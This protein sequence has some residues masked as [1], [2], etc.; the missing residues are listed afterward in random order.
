MQNY[1]ILFLGTA[2]FAVPILEGLMESSVNIQSVFTAPPKVANRGLKKTL[3]PVGKFAEEYQLPLEYP[4]LK[5]PKII[6]KIKELNPD[7]IFVIAYGYILPKEIIEIPK[8]GCFNFHGSIL[9]K[10]RGAAPIQ[11]AIIAGEKTT[12][13][14]VIKVDQGL[15]TGDIV[16]DASIEITDEDTYQDLEKKLSQLS[17]NILPMFFEKLATNTKMISQD[18]TQATYAEKI[19]KTEAKIDWQDDA[20]LINQKIRAFNPNPGAWFELEGKRI[21]IM[22]SKVIDKNGKPGEILTDEFII[23]CGSHAIQPTTLKKEGKG[24]VT[25]AEFLKG[26]Q[27][28]PGTQL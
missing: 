17:K 27:V 24:L 4:D 16:L 23:A 6:N 20:Q 28:I 21:K 3:S 26:N 13:V 19:N 12:G 14:T 2:K 22:G 8:F 1:N 10:Y 15:D 11:R 25:L 9:P 7:I 5:D 18:N